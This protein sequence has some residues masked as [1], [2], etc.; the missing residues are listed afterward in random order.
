MNNINQDAPFH[1]HLHRPSPQKKNFKPSSQPAIMWKW[2]IFLC[3]GRN[4]EKQNILCCQLI[5]I[6]QKI[7]SFWRGTR[8]K[9]RMAEGCMKFRHD[10]ETM[11]KQ[12]RKRNDPAGRGRDVSWG[13]PWSWTFCWHCQAKLIVALL[14]YPAR[15]QNT[16]N[17]VAV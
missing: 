16:L 7:I 8:R 12:E 10:L 17:C 3:C 6:H 11:S 4:A 15:V 1:L 13:R 5:K 14:W 2:H 9:E